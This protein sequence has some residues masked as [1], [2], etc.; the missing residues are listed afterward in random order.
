[1]SPP[2]APALLSPPPLRLAL[3]RAGQVYGMQDM[4]AEIAARGPITCTIGCPEVNPFTAVCAHALAHTRRRAF[5]CTHVDTHAPG[6]THTYT[7]MW[8][9]VGTRARA[10]PRSHSRATP[11]GSSMTPRDTSHRTTTSRYGRDDR[12]PRPRPRVGTN[13]HAAAPRYAHLPFVLLQRMLPVVCPSPRRL[14]GGLGD[15]C[16]RRAVLAHSQLLGRLLGR[17]GLVSPGR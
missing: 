15:D 16:S 13:R 1:M 4:M 12:I 3:P 2:T 9:H 10:C 11:E 6:D 5:A 8:T 7:H 14:G 17:A